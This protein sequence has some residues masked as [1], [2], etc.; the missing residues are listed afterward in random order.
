[1]SDGLIVKQISQRGR[2]L[3]E[4]TVDASLFSRRG[5]EVRSGRQQKQSCLLDGYSLALEVPKA[6]SAK[7]VGLRRD[8]EQ[9]SVFFSPSI[10]SGVLLENMSLSSAA[11]SFSRSERAR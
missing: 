4:A 6:V 9:T 10:V 5:G 2:S 8:T 1:M 11:V 3:S 7:R